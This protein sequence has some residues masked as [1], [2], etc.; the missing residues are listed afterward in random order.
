MGTLRNAAIATAFAAVAG[1]SPA[2]G[3][4]EDTAELWRGPLSFF[5]GSE[6]RSCG[7][8]QLHYDKSDSENSY[9]WE[10]ILDGSCPGLESA[11]FGG[12]PITTPTP[13]PTPAP[14]PAPPPAGDDCNGEWLNEIGTF[15]QVPL[16]SE[17]PVKVEGHVD[18]IRVFDK[19][20]SRPFCV[21]LAPAPDRE[22]ARVEFQASETHNHT[23]CAGLLLSA[24]PRSGPNAGQTIYTQDPNGQSFNRHSW[25][26]I[27]G[28]QVQ[29]GIW[30][31][32][33]TDKSVLADH[34]DDGAVTAR[35]RVYGGDQ[36]TWFNLRYLIYY[37]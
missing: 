5:S 31:L 25:I 6:E 20:E 29:N 26:R 15:E 19:D 33:L 21:N 22:I 13:G 16:N 14:T 24:T 23:G 1:A 4:D 17:L 36:C 12:A 9:S 2:A 8:L 28:D 7:E 10:V 32:V 35:Q 34:N 37:R 3:A 11:V 30:D 18:A 27:P